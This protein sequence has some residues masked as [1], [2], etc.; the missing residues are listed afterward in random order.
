MLLTILNAA[1]STAESTLSFQL[2]RLLREAGRKLDYGRDSANWTTEQATDVA[3]IVDTA[4]RWVD[5]P[6]NG[7][8]WSYMRPTGTLTTE[9]G[10][11]DYELPGNF[12]GIVGESMSLDYDSCINRVV[13][14]PEYMVRRNRTVDTS[15]IPRM[16]A[17][18]P[19]ANTSP[20]TPQRWEAMVWPTPDQEY[21]ITYRYRLL[22]SALRFDNEHPYGGL[23]M[24]E[25]YLQAV[26]AAVEQFD[27]DAAGEEYALFQ[28]MLKEAIAADGRMYDPD[29]YGYNGDRPAVYGKRLR[30]SDFSDP[31]IHWNGVPI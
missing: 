15:G 3:E 31:I 7:Y 22:P 5:L 18:R 24:M 20:A 25:L 12:G 9:D 11:G 26:R 21:T 6:N 29:Y 2:S 27:K 14:V 1:A 16:V 23:P 19:K 10:E 28:A 8:I 17:L 4:Q 30:A 13:V